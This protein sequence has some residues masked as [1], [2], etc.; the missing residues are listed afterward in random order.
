MRAAPNQSHGHIDMV[1]M[2]TSR[3]SE[4]AHRPVL[5]KSRPRDS[6]KRARSLAPAL[7]RVLSNM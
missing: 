5:L 2:L 3:S 7:L 6:T 1:E 4:V